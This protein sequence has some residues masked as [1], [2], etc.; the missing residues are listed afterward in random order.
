MNNQYAR[1]KRQLKNLSERLEKQLQADSPQTKLNQKLVA[2]IKHLAQELRSVFNLR[3]IRRTVGHT[4]AALI[5]LAAGQQAMGQSFKA[6]VQNP[7][8]LTA[9]IE[10]AAPTFADLDND[11]D[12]D[13]M[14]GEYYGALKYYQNT[15][16]AAAPQFSAPQTNPFGLDSLYYYAL[17]Q[18]VDLDNDGDYDLMAGEYYG[19]L[20]YF[21]NTGSAASPQ[22]AAPVTN[23]FGIAPAD[24]LA[25]HTFGDID[26]DGDLDLFTGGFD[27][28]TYYYENTGSVTAPS[29]AAGQRNPFGLTAVNYYSL[30]SLIDLDMDGDLDLLITEDYGAM[31]YFE[32]TGSASNP[33]FAAPQQNPFGLRSTYLVA[34]AAFADLDNDAD[35]DLLVGE[36]YGNMQYF[37]NTTNNVSLTEDAIAELR[38]FPNPAVDFITLEGDV[39]ITKVDIYS[40][41][42][43]LVRSIENPAARIAVADL[44]KGSYNLQVQSAEGATRIFTLMKD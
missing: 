9:T 22:F 18:L 37:E 7:F 10:I 8:G 43:A 19:D 42:G 14:A 36:Y 35:M 44:P 31:K 17:P 2:Q 23:P 34:F 38:V 33:Q 25:V 24:S 29:F 15:G 39:S 12:L 32:N 6:P 13:L 5:G 26:G 20:N 27:G 4:V 16:T 11:G 1:K 40:V 41:T 30:P 21:E 3:D 28:N